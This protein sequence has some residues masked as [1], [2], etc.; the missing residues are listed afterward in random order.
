MTSPKLQP[1][2]HN[3]FILKKGIFRFPK[4]DEHIGW[5][6]VTDT[7]E[8][9]LDTD[10]V[11]NIYD[12]LKQFN[13]MSLHGKNGLIVKK[14]FQTGTDNMLFWNS[15]AP[16]GDELTIINVKEISALLHKK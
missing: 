13:G 7:E 11:I 2:P 16:I 5:D 9:I 14:W 6:N 3:H 8:F 10:H 1:Q 12:P 4:N 15:T